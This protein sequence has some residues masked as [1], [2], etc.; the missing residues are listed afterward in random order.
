MKDFVKKYKWII[1]GAVLVAAVLAFAFFSGGSVDEAKKAVSAQASSDVSAAP[2]I[3]RANEAHADSGNSTDTSYETAATHSSAETAT[4][5]STSLTPSVPSSSAAAQTTAP[6]QK[7]TFAVKQKT[8]IKTTEPA[9]KASE[10][11]VNPTKA[12]ETTKPSGAV[13]KRCTIS[14]SCA[15][16]L[17][18]MDKLD[19]DDRELVPS[20]GW[21]LKRKA[22]FIKDGDSVFDILK[23]VCRDNNIHLEFSNTPIYNSAYIEGIG[24]LYEFSAG[25]NSG[26]MYRVN[27]KFPN[28]GC[29]R[30]EV[31]SGDTIEWMYTCNLGYDIGGENISYKD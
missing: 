11:S 2:E 6:S 29:S 7:P 21:I 28:Y 26:W 24:N 18:N 30:Y 20:D 8:E 31:K 1:I 10:P 17:N 14:I 27:G 23:R 22:V 16:L 9:S 4:N 5:P 3:S 12:A 19:E 15:T 25:A 13:K